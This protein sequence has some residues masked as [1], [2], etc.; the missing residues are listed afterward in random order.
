MLPYLSMLIVAIGASSGVA[1]HAKPPGPLYEQP[2]PCNHD[3]VSMHVKC[4]MNCANGYK[5]KFY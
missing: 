5:I 1:K 4:A 2:P 3:E